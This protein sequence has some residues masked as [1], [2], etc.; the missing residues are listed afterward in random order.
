MAPAIMCFGSKKDQDPLA[1]RNEE[2]ERMIRA[3]RKRQEKEV[4]LLLLGKGGVLRL[5]E[6]R[7]VLTHHKALVRV[8]SRRS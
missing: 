4:K 8:E 2:I 3:D 5:Q 1:R 6:S 7:R